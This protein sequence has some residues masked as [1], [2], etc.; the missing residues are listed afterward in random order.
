MNRKQ[1]T[2][3]SIDLDYWMETS[4]R[5]RGL[6]KVL[7]H[8]PEHVS[9]MVTHDH[10]HLLPHI[11]RFKNT[12]IRL[13]NIDAHSDLITETG[14]DEIDCGTWGAAPYIGWDRTYEFVWCFNRYHSYTLKNAILNGR[15]DMYETT[16]NFSELVELQN[17]HPKWEVI[18]HRHGIPLV[19]TMMDVVGVGIAISSD[20]IVGHEWSG[21]HQAEVFCRQMGFSRM[22]K[23][24]EYWMTSVKM[25]LGLLE[26]TRKPFWR[27]PKKLKGIK[28][29][30]WGLV[31]GKME[32]FTG[33][34]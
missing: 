21:E 14:K 24:G 17:G 22:I 11:H 25:I 31:N 9:V 18:R 8:I 6:I 4:S 28:D 3:L 30:C 13:I 5:N 26:K 10:Q 7:R 34:N 15:C 20:Y 23:P 27:K 16:C 33:W 32:P 2:Y 19:K 29:W 12:A 1:G